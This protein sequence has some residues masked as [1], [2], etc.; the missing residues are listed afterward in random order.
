MYKNIFSRVISALLL[1][2]CLQVVALAK[3]VSTG[4][5]ENSSQAPSATQ[6]LEEPNNQKIQKTPAIATVVLYFENDLFY[7]T[8]KYYTN[9]VQ[10][11]LI[12]PPLN[13][14]IDNK[15]LPDVFDGLLDKTEDIQSNTL[16]YNLSAGFGQIIYTPEDT[17]AR[18]LQQEDRPYAGHL[19]GFLAI[20][21]KRQHIMD[22]A[23]LRFGI[24]GPS[25][26]GEQAQNETHRFRGFDTAK[27]WQHQLRDEPTLG[28]TWTRNY[29]LNH[30]AVN[31]GWNW[32]AL[33]YHSLTAGNALTQAAA[34]VELRY[35]YNL[36]GSFAS[37]QIRHG[38]GID[39][40]LPEDKR[41]LQTDKL[42][43]YLFAGLEGRAIA[44][45]I[46][47][48]GNT[49]KSSHSVDKNIFVGEFNLGVALIYDGMRIAYNHVYKTKEFENQ[50]GSGQHFGSIT[51][52]FPF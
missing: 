7:D 38:S 45:N 12:S 23:E 40:P 31:N 52:S 44:H 34:G 48:D 39:A 24:V 18:E 16:Q 37:S 36:P 4:A 29:R 8:D 19:Y 46:F 6:P 14:L 51:L 42:G 35:G 32:D 41:H 17:D 10:L 13:R 1:V 11:R 22:T 26:L 15:I 20:H 5:E 43:Y 9:A 49:W 33:P 25:A 28:L 21:A 27:G 50:S 30:E 47:L 3:S 2:C